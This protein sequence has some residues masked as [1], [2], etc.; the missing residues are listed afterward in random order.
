[1][2]NSPLTSPISVF[3][4]LFLQMT[5]LSY[6]RWTQ[7]KT[8]S[9]SKLNICDQCPA[10]TYLNYLDSQIRPQSKIRRHNCNKAV[11]L[12]H[13]TYK[14][15]S[16]SAVSKVNFALLVYLRIIDDINV[17]K[18]HHLQEHRR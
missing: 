4:P 10:K 5:P 9:Y 11:L 13:V 18:W 1:M 3:S 17:N 14:W 8:D 15:L 2:P 12:A 6:Y 16:S 7:Q